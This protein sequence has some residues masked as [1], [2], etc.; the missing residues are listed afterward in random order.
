VF[1][2]ISSADEKTFGYTRRSVFGCITFSEAPHLAV[3]PT[4][5]TIML[6]LCNL[7]R[8]SCGEPA[9]PKLLYPI[10]WIPCCGIVFAGV[11]KQSRLCNK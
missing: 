7:A 1:P 5:M 3:V 4:G 8:Q 10:V 6:G 2:R 11:V 9:K